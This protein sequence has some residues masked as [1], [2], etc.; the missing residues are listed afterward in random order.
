MILVHHKKL[1]VCFVRHIWMSTNQNVQYRKFGRCQGSARNVFSFDTDVPQ[2]KFLIL[3]SIAFVPNGLNLNL[4]FLF[5]YT[6]F[7]VF[8]WKQDLDVLKMNNHGCVMCVCL[9]KR[10]RWRHIFA[11]RN[12]FAIVW[13]F[14]K[15]KYQENLYISILSY[16]SI[17]NQNHVKIYTKR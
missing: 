7:F 5:L 10:L 16:P 6:P 2:I 12:D 1:Y 3:T 8:P 15:L 13:H 11:K 9:M 17:Y 4:I 14:N